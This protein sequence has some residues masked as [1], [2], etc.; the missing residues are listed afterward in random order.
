MNA[1]KGEHIYSTISDAYY[2]IAFVVGGDDGG[3]GVK[4]LL[5]VIRWFRTFIHFH[6]YF[7]LGGK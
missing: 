1:R 7:F 5:V 2:S 6:V 3:D 4:I